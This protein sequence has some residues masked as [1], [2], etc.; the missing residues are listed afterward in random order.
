MQNVINHHELLI[1]KTNYS[2]YSQYLINHNSEFQWIVSHEIKKFHGRKTDYFL[3]DFSRLQCDY[4]H[5]SNSPNA[6]NSINS[7]DSQNATDTQNPQNGI[8]VKLPICVIN[9]TSETPEIAT[10][11]FVV[12]GVITPFGSCGTFEH[13]GCEFVRGSV[14]DVMIVDAN[15]DENDYYVNNHSS[16]QEDAFEEMKWNRHESSTFWSDN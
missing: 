6:T 2:S 12:H 7:T 8:H 4:S 9:Q 5:S 15:F 10:K 1:S 14:N 16:K 3:I 11:E 13:E